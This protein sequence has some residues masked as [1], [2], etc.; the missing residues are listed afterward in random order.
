M[1]QIGIRDLKA[2][3]SGIIKHV[4][5]SRE[6]Y[7]VTNHG[8]AVGVLSPAIPETDNSAGIKIVPCGQINFRHEAG[9][10]TENHFT[11]L[12]ESIQPP[13]R[14]AACGA[15]RHNTTARIRPGGSGGPALP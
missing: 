9:R 5:E 6:T 1:K 8:H 11:T 10:R 7:I 2:R 12:S 14:A 13:R 4:A 15:P 3:A